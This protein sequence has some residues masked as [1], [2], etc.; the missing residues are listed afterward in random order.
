MLVYVS[1]SDWSVVLVGA[2]YTCLYLAVGTTRILSPIS[3]LQFLE[4]GRECE[5]GEFY[6][7]FIFFAASTGR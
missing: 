6:G 4:S 3:F 1:L 2:K 7:F 5:D